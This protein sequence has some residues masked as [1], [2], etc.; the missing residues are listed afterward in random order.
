M[1]IEVSSSPGEVVKHISGRLRTLASP[2][3]SGKFY[4]IQIYLQVFKRG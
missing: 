4:R 2:S 1:H 3:E